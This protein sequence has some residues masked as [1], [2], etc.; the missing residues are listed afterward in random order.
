MSYFYMYL[1]CT[2]NGPDRLAKA[3]HGDSPE[4]VPFPVGFDDC[5]LSGGVGEGAFAAS[6]RLCLSAIS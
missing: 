2:R 3:T 1:G 4:A 6:S 5:Q